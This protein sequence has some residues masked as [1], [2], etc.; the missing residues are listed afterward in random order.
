M[1]AREPGAGTKRREFLGLLSGARMISSP[2]L[3][4]GWL[5][6][7]QTA[8]QA[9][10]RNG[11][12]ARVATVRSVVGDDEVLGT[13][14]TIWIVISRDQRRSSCHKPAARRPSPSHP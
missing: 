14:D 5:L 13:R 6:R 11:A 12:L 10:A 7:F 2:P 4:V 3:S 1:P 9:F 8:L